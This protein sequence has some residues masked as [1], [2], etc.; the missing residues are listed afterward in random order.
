MAQVYSKMEIPFMYGQ[1]ELEAMRSL[2]IGLEML[3]IIYYWIMN[4]IPE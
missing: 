3:L 4:G 1:I 2:L